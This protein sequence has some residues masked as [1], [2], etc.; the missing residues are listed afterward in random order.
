MTALEGMASGQAAAGLSVRVLS[1][2]SRRG[3]ATVCAALEAA[4]VEVHELQG[5]SAG[6]RRHRELCPALRR[7]LLDTDAVHIHSMWEQPQHV[8]ARLAVECGVPYIISPHGM[9]DPWSLGQSKWKK[10]VYLRL[11]GLTNL[12]RAARLHFTTQTERDLAAPF[13]RP[14]QDLVE[15][16]GV[17]V[18]TLG[19]PHDPAL[20]LRRR[21]RLSEGP[22]LLFF[23]RLHPKKQPEILIDAFSRL[24]KQR[25]DGPR[26][27]LVLAG[28]ADPAYEA[29]LRHRVASS[30]TAHATIFTGPLAGADRVA[31]LRSAD[32]FCLPSQQENFGLAVAESLAAGTPVLISDQVNIWREITEA[33]V[34]WAT[35]PELDPYSTRLI[36]LCR[37]PGLLLTTAKRTVAYAG[38][39][40]DWSQISKRW[41]EHYSKL[42]LR[43]AEP[44]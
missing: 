13:R 1:T 27:S 14:G 43:E 18:S 2:Q 6:L 26:P 17:D 11:R 29:A 10:R 42:P 32:L 38:E 5:A 40:Y 30:G 3:E 24:L 4:G 25:A 34:G 15:P 35:S 31:A 12:R 28:P 22:V 21:H 19:V 37:D 41:L 39:T 36:E 20:D 16:L 7:L 33:R 8:A 23:G 44:A 9:L